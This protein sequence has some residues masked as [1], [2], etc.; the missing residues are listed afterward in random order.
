MRLTHDALHCLLLLPHVAAHSLVHWCCDACDQEWVGCCI[1][2][3][4]AWDEATSVGRREWP[5][6]QYSE[7][8]L[9]DCVAYLRDH[10][11]GQGSQDF[12]RNDLTTHS[13]STHLFTT[14]SLTSPFENP[15]RGLNK[16]PI[17]CYCTATSST[18]LLSHW[19][20]AI[21]LPSPVNGDASS[22]LAAY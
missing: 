18:A 4:F 9:H 16:A 17:H 12:T 10:V 1:L 21:N 6:G 5:V 11:H 8:K 20:Q 3:V 13:P 15:N 19:L 22:L 14:L 7:G 2:V